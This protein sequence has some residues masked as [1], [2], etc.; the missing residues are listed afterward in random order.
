MKGRGLAFGLSTPASRQRNSAHKAS[1]K[2]SVANASPASAGSIPKYAEPLTAAIATSM[3]CSKRRF[4][5]V[6]PWIGPGRVVRF[7]VDASNLRRPRG[8]RV[9]ELSRKAVRHLE[10]S[11]E[12][13]D[14]TDMFQYWIASC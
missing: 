12:V 3:V 1:A 14:P 7:I 6:G 11:F 9:P 2:L 13:R 8:S 10:L 4:M 5:F